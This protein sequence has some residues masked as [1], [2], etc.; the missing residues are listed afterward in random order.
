MPNNTVDDEM[1]N[2]NDAT[3]AV[4]AAVT[5]LT[6]TAAG[7]ETPLAIQGKRN[8]TASRSHP[9]QNPPVDPKSNEEDAKFKM[10]PSKKWK[11]LQCGL[12]TNTKHNVLKHIRAR[13]ADHKEKPKKK[14]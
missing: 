14:N 6:T 9:K 10:T 13:A 7:V 8:A 2:N 11:C 3:R 12:V 5:G 1:W 4:K